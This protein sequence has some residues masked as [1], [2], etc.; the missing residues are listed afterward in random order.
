MAVPSRNGNAYESLDLSWTLPSAPGGTLLSCTIEF[1]TIEFVAAP[2]PPIV[3][4]N[5]G[6]PPP[7]FHTISSL[8]SGMV[9]QFNIYCSNSLNGA[10]VQVT[11]TT[12][13]G[14]IYMLIHKIY[15]II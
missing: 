6:G 4:F 10:T 5:T 7:T 11:G 3:L 12:E 1:G 15:A 8:A 14:G 9:H 2:R 13:L